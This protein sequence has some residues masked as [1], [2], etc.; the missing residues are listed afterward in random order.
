MVGGAIAPDDFNKSSWFIHIYLDF[1]AVRR[2][3]G[4]GCGLMR[5]YMDAIALKGFS[6]EF[7]F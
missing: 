6:L 5:S 4:A 3:Q 7:I 1:Y 2:K